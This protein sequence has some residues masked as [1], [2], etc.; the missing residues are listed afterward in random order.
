MLSTYTPTPQPVH[1]VML[2]LETLGTHPYAP[3]IAVGAVLFKPFADP[4]DRQT[5]PTFHARASIQ[6]NLDLGR[7]PDGGSLEF[8]LKSEN[9]DAW[10]QIE[11]LEALDLVN[12]LE[13]FRDWM[14]GHTVFPANPSKDRA[15]Y[16]AVWGNGATF[17]NVLLATAYKQA[18]MPLPWSYKYDRCYRTFR[19]LRPD[20][21]V[22]A[23]G[24]HHNALDDAL[25]QVSTLIAVRHALDLK[26]L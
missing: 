22:D 15:D 1:H 7:M 23:V 18:G 10:A 12:V 25:H 8:W 17:D 5:M 26:V 21:V 9:R 16:V 14:I 24:T 19:A 3:I 4:D 20:I 6:S 11:K 13:G 2:D